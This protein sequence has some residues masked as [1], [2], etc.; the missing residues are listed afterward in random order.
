MSRRT[1]RAAV[2]MPLERSRAQTLRYPSPVKGELAMISRIA[3]RR[4]ASLAG[5]RGPRRRGGRG[6]FA[7]CLARW[8]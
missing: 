1:R 7:A 5:P 8:R 2:R 3:T 6:S 4:M